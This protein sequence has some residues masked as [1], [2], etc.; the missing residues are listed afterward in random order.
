M[1]Y[2]IEAH[3]NHVIESPFTCYDWERSKSYIGKSLREIYP[4]GKI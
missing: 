1:Y 4:V 3:K 2:D